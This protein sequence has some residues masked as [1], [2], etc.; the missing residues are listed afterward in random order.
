MKC[1]VCGADLQK[2]V[3]DLPFKVAS[4]STVI[5]NDLPVLECP[6]CS[7][8]GLEDPVMAQVDRLLKSVHEGTRLEIVQY[9][10]A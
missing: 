8:I 7:E 5:V 2:T 1:R 10:A 3:M 6:Q 4:R 9:A